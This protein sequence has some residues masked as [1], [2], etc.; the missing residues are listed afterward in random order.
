MLEII[1]V[2]LVTSAEMISEEEIG[3]VEG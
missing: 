1:L 3:I 2:I